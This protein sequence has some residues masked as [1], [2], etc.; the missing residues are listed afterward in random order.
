MRDPPALA[1]VEC[2]NDH[3]LAWDKRCT[4]F[5][6]DGT[7]VHFGK[8]LRKAWP[9]APLPTRQVRDGAAGHVIRRRQR[10]HHPPELT[11]DLRT[12]G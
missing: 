11:W 1:R 6:S 5:G 2:A 12:L 4:R 9:K 10:C 3:A 8:R 7:V